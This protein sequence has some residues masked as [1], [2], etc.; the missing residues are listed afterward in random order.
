MI[1][2]Q[3][4]LNNHTSEK[5]H[6]S[7]TY[8]CYIFH[9]HTTRNQR[10]TEG[11]KSS[12]CRRNNVIL[13]IYRRNKSSE[14]QFSS[15]I[16]RIFPTEFRGNEFPRKLRGPPVRSSENPRKGICRNGEDSPE[17]SS[18]EKVENAGRRE[19]SPERKKREMGKKMRF[20]FIKPRVRRI[21]SVGI[22]SVFSI[23]IFAKY[24][25]ACLP[26]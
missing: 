1:A 4:S 3:C 9:G 12:V 23:S 8:A 7:F 26:G 24:L 13:T 21:F 25:A 5:S 18:R 14:I 22:P 10:H 17:R 20:E 11:K 16:P 19:R 2:M 6:T 15:E